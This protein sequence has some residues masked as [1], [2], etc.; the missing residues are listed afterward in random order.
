[1]TM[2]GSTLTA[3]VVSTDVRVNGAR[4][5]QADLVATNVIVH[6]IDEVILPKNWHLLAPAA[7]RVLSQAFFGPEF[8]SSGC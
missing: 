7:V 2:Q 4:I 8:H 5:K 6:A 1:M 3:T